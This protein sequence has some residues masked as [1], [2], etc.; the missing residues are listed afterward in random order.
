MPSGFEKK[1]TDKQTNRCIL[2]PSYNI[3]SLSCNFEYSWH[4][5]EVLLLS[6]VRISI[7]YYITQT[8]DSRTQGNHKAV[9]QIMGLSH[10]RRLFNIINGL[11]MKG[12]NH[13][14]ITIR[15]NM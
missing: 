7:L 4:V 6:K 12:F 1:R 2:Q 11:K 10:T 13:T 9:S 3:I 14:I 8:A 5:F 15:L